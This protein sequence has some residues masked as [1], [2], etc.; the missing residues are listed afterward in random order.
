MK[1]R[2]SDLNRIILQV[3]EKWVDFWRISRN[4]DKASNVYQRQINDYAIVL[5]MNF[6]IIQNILQRLIKNISW[7]LNLWFPGFFLDIYQQIL[8]DGYVGSW[9]LQKYSMDRGAWKDTV[10]RVAK[11]QIPLSTCI[12]REVAESWRTKAWT[13]MGFCHFLAIGSG[14]VISVPYAF[15]YLLRKQLL[16]DSDRMIHAHSPLHG[17]GTWQECSKHAVCYCCF[18]GKGRPT[19]DKVRWNHYSLSTSLGLS[20]DFGSFLLLISFN[21]NNH[22]DHKHRKQ[23]GEHL[24]GVLL[25]LSN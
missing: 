1:L 5:G 15:V 14:Q 22:Q 19:E 7:K 25:T 20:I 21:P 12:H 8:A 17:P 24:S 13:Q 10:H 4:W 3:F 23:S 9:R 11:S 6:K 18:P 2:L 16:W